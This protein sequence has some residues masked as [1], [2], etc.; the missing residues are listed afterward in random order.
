MV[1]KVCIYVTFYKGVNFVAD[2]KR[3]VYFATFF[4]LFVLLWA[5]ILA[6]VPV[7]IILREI[8]TC[9]LNKKIQQLEEVTKSPQSI[10]L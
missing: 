7:I 3:F 5:C 1:F 2:E 6:T 8:L 10:N 9:R 4:W